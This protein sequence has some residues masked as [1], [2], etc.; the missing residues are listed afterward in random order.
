MT[1]P[2]DYL[3]NG[4]P[5]RPMTQTEFVS[6]LMASRRST[7][8]SSPMLKGA[9]LKAARIALYKQIATAFPT[10]ME[11]DSGEL[12]VKFRGG[13]F[14]IKVTHKKDGIPQEKIT[15]INEN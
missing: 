15:K 13:T 14:T 5:Y 10:T 8:R 1:K 6:K 2:K 9:E 12:G 4:K 3:I 11:L 7:E